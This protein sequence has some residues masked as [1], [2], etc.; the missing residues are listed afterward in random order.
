MKEYIVCCNLQ[1]F[2]LIKHFST[3]NHVIWKQTKKCQIGEIVY[4]YVGRP[5]SRLYYKC[6]VK[7]NNMQDD[8]NQETI[9]SN[10]IGKQRNSGF[11]ELELVSVLAEEGMGLQSLLDNG[12]KTVQCTTEVDESLHN[13]IEKWAR[14]GN[15]NGHIVR[16]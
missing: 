16:G 5:Y 4:I 10:G 11:M 1:R 14:K 6:V 12:L 8:N 7:K 13:Y 9:Y 3:N 15:N 2:D